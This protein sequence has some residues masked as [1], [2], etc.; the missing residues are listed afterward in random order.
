MSDLSLCVKWTSGCPAGTMYVDGSAVADRTC[1]VPL[2]CPALQD[3]SS[4]SVL[5]N[6]SGVFAEVFLLTVGPGYTRNNSAPLFCFPDGAWRALAYAG[7]PV[8]SFKDGIPS[9]QPSAGNIFRHTLTG[10][11][12]VACTGTT[13][14]PGNHPSSMAGCAVHDGLVANGE[15]GILMYMMIPDQSPY[16]GSI[17]FGVTSSGSSGTGSS[18]VYLSSSNVQYIPV[19]QVDF[20]SNPCPSG[21]YKSLSGNAPCTPKVVT[22]CPAGQGF[23]AGSTTVTSSCSACGSGTY[24]SAND[25]S[26]CS[27]L[28]NLSC[29]PGQQWSGSTTA[30]ATCTPCVAQTWNGVND[31]SPCA[32]WNAT[33]PAGHVYVNGSAVADRTCV[34]PNAVLAVGS[35][36]LVAAE[37]LSTILLVAIIAVV[38]SC[39]LL[40]VFLLLRKRSHRVDVVFA[41]N[42][43]EA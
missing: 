20:K 12:T 17:Q 21:T 43:S 39:V 27:P 19:S 13:V 34:D 38:V 11:S 31:Q 25:Q 37:G 9:S 8:S 22:A 14:H 15:A 10:D 2:A 29:P 24:S 4:N 30:D 3:I 16:V 41:S 42:T 40:V 33:C 7:T 23:N 36:S 26:A 28:T 18:M 1:V 35:L 5:Q 32:A 6:I